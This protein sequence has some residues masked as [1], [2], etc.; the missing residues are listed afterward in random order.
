MNSF[1]GSLTRPP[2]RALGSNTSHRREERTKEG[3]KVWAEYL[4]SGRAADANGAKLKAQRL[5]KQAADAAAAAKPAK[6]RES[7]KPSA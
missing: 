2:S 7:A 3:E 4:A 6:S 1:A 5:A